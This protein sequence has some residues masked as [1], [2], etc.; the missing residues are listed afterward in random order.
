MGTPCR[1]FIHCAIVYFSLS[2]VLGF[3]HVCTGEVYKLKFIKYFEHDR[4][5]AVCVVGDLTHGYTRR[6]VLP[7]CVS[8][9]LRHKSGC[10]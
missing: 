1:L 3:V 8:T 7:I 6:F 2:L 4:K 10:V 5:T 9:A